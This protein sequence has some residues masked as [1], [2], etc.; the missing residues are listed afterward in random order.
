L[1]T[2]FFFIIF[3]CKKDDS[4]GINNILWL[5]MFGYRFTDNESIL[6]NH[7][8]VQLIDIKTPIANRKSKRINFVKSYN[9]LSI[10]R[11][12]SQ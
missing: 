5:E 11:F 6:N 4:H 10:L 1:N 7:N 3:S 8:N 9:K 12:V 2:Y